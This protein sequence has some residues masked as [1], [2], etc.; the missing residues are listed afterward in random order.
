M[1]P[2]MT[3]ALIAKDR[4]LEA[5]GGEGW[6][7]NEP[8]GVNGEGNGGQFPV[9]VA[10]P[11]GG[12][13]SV[14]FHRL[15]PYQVGGAR[16]HW[17]HRGIHGFTRPLSEMEANLLLVRGHVLVG[18]ATV[19]LREWDGWTHNIRRDFHTDPEP[20]A[21]FARRVAV[22]VG[23]SRCVT[24]PMR[25][26][27]QVDDRSTYDDSPRPLITSPHGVLCD[28]DLVEE[29]SHE[30]ILYAF[31]P[32]AM[33]EYQVPA[34][35]WVPMEGTVHPPLKRMYP[36]NPN[37]VEERAYEEEREALLAAYDE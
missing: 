4:L 35:E 5:Y 11:G 17:K 15:A 31:G 9:F 36:L 12:A 7:H 26:F 3:L 25:A 30:F 16:F 28:L 2:L 6:V 19:F 23:S 20:Y 24:V 29:A 32:S 37:E 18:D 21:A 1:G 14:L 13:E 10:W 27:P 34:P 22:V 33:E 8:T